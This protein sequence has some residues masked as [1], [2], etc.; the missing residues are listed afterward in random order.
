MK[1]I[2]IAKT[3]WFF[4]WIYFLIYNIYFRFNWEA[5]SVA[6]SNCDTVFKIALYGAFI[7]Y[8][9]PFFNMYEKAAESFQNNK[10]K[11][12]QDEKTI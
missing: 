8:V 5:K 4:N 10:S 1:N 6:E 9:L 2:N 7:I 12:E 11:L 3:I